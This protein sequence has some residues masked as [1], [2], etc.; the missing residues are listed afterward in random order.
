MQ[1]LFNW[2]YFSKAFHLKQKNLP[3]YETHLLLDGQ[4]LGLHRSYVFNLYS[5]LVPVKLAVH[6]QY[7]SLLFFL[8]HL[9]IKFIISAL[10]KYI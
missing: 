7:P 2:I 9:P 4:G 5:H 3:L 6:T 8:T 1:S 10:K